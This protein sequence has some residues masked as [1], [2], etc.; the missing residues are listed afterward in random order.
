MTTKPQLLRAASF[1]P[2]ETDGNTLVGYAAVF[3]ERTVIN[4]WDGTYAEQIAP[5]AFR[6]TLRE[7][8]P[9]LQF[10]HGF[11]PLVGSIPIGSID[12]LQEDERGLY[13]E[14][15]LHDNW[16][17]QPVRD[18]I[19]SGAIDGM[20][21]RFAVIRDEWERNGGPNDVR[22]IREVALYELGP[23]VFPAYEATQVGLRSANQAEQMHARLAALA[24]DQEL[25]RRWRMD[26][27]TI[28]TSDLAPTLVVTQEEAVTQE[29]PGS[30]LTAR[31]RRIIA[32]R[33]RMG[34]TQ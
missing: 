12:T 29:P 27:P 6:K 21:F 22:T 20:S 24:N 28:D 15:T 8:T 33:L 2:T 23:V 3:N 14:A 9:V 32:A 4:D 10:D 19:E 5:G 31:E 16:M 1:T 26:A 7:R 34:E 17:V 11:H 25:L 13:V 30:K 18:A